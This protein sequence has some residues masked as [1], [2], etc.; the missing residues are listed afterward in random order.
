[1]LPRPGFCFMPIFRSQLGCYVRPAMQNV[2]NCLLQFLAAGVLENK[3]NWSEFEC[4]CSKIWA[5]VH[6][7]KDEL[8]ARSLYFAKPLC[9]IA[10]VE[11]LL[12]RQVRRGY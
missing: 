12:T 7:Q 3:R 4:R 8:D 9:R 1:M 5:V 2:L 6:R 10:S 11:R